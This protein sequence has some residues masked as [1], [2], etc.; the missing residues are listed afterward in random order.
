[1]K[2]LSHDTFLFEKYTNMER[3]WEEGTG[4]HILSG[5]HSTVLGK[6]SLIRRI[7]ILSIN[8]HLASI[9]TARKDINSADA[10]KFSN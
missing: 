4:K 3:V 8:T 5:S 6:V 2:C 1:M 7:N 10:M 9:H